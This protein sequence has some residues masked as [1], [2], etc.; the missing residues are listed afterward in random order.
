MEIA[1]ERD[2]VFNRYGGKCAFC[3]TELDKGWHISPL[4]PTEL[5]VTNDGSLEKI[6]NEIENKIP[7]C[8][9]CD[10]SRIQLSYGAK[11]M[12]VEQFK[13]SLLHSF[14]FIQGNADYKKAIRFGLITETQQPIVFYF[15]NVNNI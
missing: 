13:K 12:T 14:E 9:A 1:K 15:E 4:I 8:K 11:T 2:I 3:G 10:S 6:N 7:S 5:V